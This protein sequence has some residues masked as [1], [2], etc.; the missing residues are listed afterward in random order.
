MHINVSIK[1]KMKNKGQRQ[2]EP[3]SNWPHTY[4]PSIIQYKKS[5]CEFSTASW[6]PFTVSKTGLM[7]SNKNNALKQLFI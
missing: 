5:L 3:N 7:L 2:L 4:R 1:N 6:N